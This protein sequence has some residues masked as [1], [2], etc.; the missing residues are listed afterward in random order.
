[1]A[2]LTF[3]WHK[4]PYDPKDYLHKRGVYP[5]PDRSNN[6]HLL[7]PIRNQLNSSSCVGFGIGININSV[8]KSLGI[9]TEWVSPLYLYN[10]ARFLEGTLPFDLG[11]YPKDALDWTL[12]NGIL[13]EQ[14]WPYAGF[15][16]AAPSSA[17]MKQAVHYK[18]F[19]YFRCVDGVD[20]IC[21]ALSNGH[22]VSVGSPWFKE[23]E[24]TDACG[25]LAKPTNSSFEIG[26]HETCYLDYD[27]PE[28]IFYCAN[29]WDIVW[30]DKGC[31]IMP[32]ESIDIFKQRGG[33]DAHYVIFTKDVTTEPVNPNPGCNPFTRLFR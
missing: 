16:R 27:R 2:E 1:M 10:G 22:F 25:R 15:D 23:W 18:D 12:K 24:N 7:T 11:C 5:L 29:S 30:G 20:G 21:D 3:G 9:Y 28:G 26:G 32:F 8:L 33:Y 31:F 19:A 4:D 17:R 14:Y 6:K 13:L